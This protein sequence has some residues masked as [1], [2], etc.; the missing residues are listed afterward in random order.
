[1]LFAYFEKVRQKPK[2]AR[3]RHVLFISG[4]CTL[5]IVL[6]WVISI[7]ITSF[8]NRG[9]EKE[10]VE[11]KKVQDMKARFDDANT[12]LSA[13]EEVVIPK[14]DTLF[15]VDSDQF[16]EVLTQQQT[17]TS[18]SSTRSTVEHATTSFKR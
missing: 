10:V 16:N 2:E 17:A 7:L 13:P 5:L 9:A 18:A 8:G 11:E 12:F 4:L 3:Q 15:K 1:M 14:D 6:I